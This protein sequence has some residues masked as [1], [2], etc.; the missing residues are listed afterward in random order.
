MSTIHNPVNFIPS[1]YTVD[2]YLDNKAPDANEFFFLSGIDGSAAA[3]MVKAAREQFNADF[4]RY[5]GFRDAENKHA[6]IPHNCAHCGKSIRYVVAAKYAPT[7][8]YVAIGETCAQR[9]DMTLDQFRIK[10]LHEVAAK[11]NKTIAAGGKY[12][13]YLEEHADFAEAV[14]RYYEAGTEVSNHFVND[15]LSKLRRYGSL[16]DAQRDGVINAI[17]RGFEFAARKAERVQ[18]DAEEREAAI[19]AGV[20]MVEGRR[21]ISGE[22]LSV[23]SQDSYY[24]VTVKML[25]KDSDGLKYW[26]TV[27]A[28]INPERGDTVTFTATVKKS[29]DDDMFG[30]FSRPS[31]ASI[32]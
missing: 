30:F 16:S 17:N 22:V 5:F 28:A 4:G 2:G 20:S 7:G 14:G 12:N 8:E 13:A 23:K 18:R 1:D 32:V 9:I 15:V 19:A 11:R 27:P 10:K 31:K 24:G 29:D 6:V 26:G 25:V 21:E 3:N